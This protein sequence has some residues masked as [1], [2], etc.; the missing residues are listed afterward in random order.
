VEKDIQKAVEL[1][2]R[3]AEQGDSEAQSN[4]NLLK[5]NNC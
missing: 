2:Q 5:N 4:F 1:C 3:A